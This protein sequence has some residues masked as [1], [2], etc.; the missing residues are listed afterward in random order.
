VN[1]VTF[2]LPDQ[3][4]LH[5]LDPEALD[6]DRDWEVFGTGVYVWVLQTFLRLR[7]AGA[8]VR[9]SRTAPASG[10]VVT[11]A[12]YVERLLAEAPSAARLTIVA[13]R[14][15]RPR[16]LY[17]DV[18]VVQNAS[19]VEEFQIFIPSWLQPG[20]IPRSASRGIRVE[21][22]AYVG[23]RKQ[24]HDAL[25]SDD[26]IE[27][28]RSRGLSWES[29]IVTFG[30]N[31]QR[32]SQ[33]GWNDYSTTDLV[34]AVRP[35]TMWD[36]TSKPA[37]KLTN[38]WAA[39]VPAIV[40]PEVA[41]RELRR[42]PLDYLEARDTGE[43]L[44][45]VDRLRSDPELYRAMI[46]NGFARAR[47]FEPRRIADQWVQALWQTVPYRTRSAVFRLGARVRGYRARVRWYRICASKQNKPLNRLHQAH[48]QDPSVHSIT[49]EPF[50]NYLR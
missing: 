2:Y 46:E 37:A 9:L 10:V 20:L 15:D 29:R 11:H 16:Q 13:T 21:N 34:V 18:E 3:R 24:L 43:V 1:V 4:A 26:W 39:G 40:S 6:C 31:D 5:G 44:A 41:Y 33:H 27:A 14:A 17:A 8:A 12:D 48:P 50:S 38:A 42:S 36:D 28:L 32:Y 22:V 47:D 19:S 49:T 7:D 25:A 30:G 35:P 45:A 23:A